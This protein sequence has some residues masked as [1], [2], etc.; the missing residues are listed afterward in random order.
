MARRRK[1]QAR[2]TLME[3]GLDTAIRRSRRTVR[4]PTPSARPRAAEA[5]AARRATSRGSSEAQAAAGRG[6][7]RSAEATAAARSEARLAAAGTGRPRGAETRAATQ[8]S[9][10]D[11]PSVQKPIDPRAYDMVGGV[12]VSRPPIPFTTR[13]AEGDMVS[14]VPEVQ[15]PRAVSSPWTGARPSRRRATQPTSS[16]DVLGEQISTRRRKQ[17]STPRDV[18]AGPPVPRNKA[19]QDSTD[20][21]LASEYERLGLT[22]NPYKPTPNKK[23]NN[24]K[25]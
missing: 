19:E 9:R 23:K 25:K 14:G 12:P 11:T 13:N 18:L 16:G 21:W 24:K 5:K 7:S 10:V 22:Q 3:P 8:R 2:D 6:R 17:P 1:T 15:A 20:R 4:K